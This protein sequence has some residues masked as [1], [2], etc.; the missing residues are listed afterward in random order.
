MGAERVVEIG[1]EREGLREVVR[2]DAAQVGLTKKVSSFLGGEGTRADTERWCGT[3]A[4]SLLAGEPGDAVED[5]GFLF[6]TSVANEF[7]NSF[8]KSFCMGAAA[9]VTSLAGGFGG[10]SL[11]GMLVFMSVAKLS[12]GLVWPT[13]DC[14]AVFL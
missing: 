3:G 12:S 13:D 10:D 7:F 2:E 14:D 11:Y 9:L 1:V 8:I 4:E 5:T 6:T